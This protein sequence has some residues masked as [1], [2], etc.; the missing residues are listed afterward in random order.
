MRDYDDDEVV[1]ESGGSF[2]AFLW[3]ALIGAGAM[4]LF[5]PRSG[6]ETRRELSDSYRRLRDTADAALKDMQETV[7]EK[8]RDV[9]GSVDSHVDATR[10]AFDAS[11]DAARGARTDLGQRWEQGREGVRSAYRPRPGAPARDPDEE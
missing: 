2:G 8:V 3:G 4:L 10:S 11:R 9:R 6:A 1:V 5:A 7:T